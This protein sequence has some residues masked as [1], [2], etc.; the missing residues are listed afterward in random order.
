MMV[1]GKQR[2]ISHPKL[3][4]ELGYKVRKQVENEDSLLEHQRAG[5]G[6]KKK[7]SSRVVLAVQFSMCLS[8]RDY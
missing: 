7:I 8:T 4:R 1:E 3:T 6:R 2:S 5:R